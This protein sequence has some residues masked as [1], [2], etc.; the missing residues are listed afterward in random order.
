MFVSSTFHSLPADA[1]CASF[2]V[3]KRRGFHSTRVACQLAIVVS[4]GASVCTS[5]ILKSGGA[6]RRQ[7][8]SGH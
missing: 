5:S 3:K 4:G 8:S 7:E 2:F 1:C 6:F